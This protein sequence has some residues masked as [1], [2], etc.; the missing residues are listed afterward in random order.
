MA[1]VIFAAHGNDDSGMAAA[2]QTER[3]IER[4]TFHGRESNLL[5][6]NPSLSGI[7]KRKDF[8]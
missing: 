5:T 1:V 3:E 6:P 4:L 7:R 2:V 8:P